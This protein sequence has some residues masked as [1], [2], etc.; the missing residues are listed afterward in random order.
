MC[1]GPLNL[2]WGFET[3]SSKWLMA[4]EKWAIENIEMNYC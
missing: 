4:L 1:G 3:T 2:I